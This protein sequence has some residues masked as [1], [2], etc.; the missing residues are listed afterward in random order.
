MGLNKFGL[1]ALRTTAFGQCRGCVQTCAQVLLLRMAR[2]HTSVVTGN[3]NRYTALAGIV[4][5]LCAAQPR[6]RSKRYR[7]HGGLWPQWIGAVLAGRVCRYPA[8]PRASRIASPDRAALGMK[9]RAG[10]AAT[11]SAK[12]SSACVEIKI[13]GTSAPKPFR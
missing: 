13:V 2:L 12:S 4:P 7:G 11:S 8:S 3:A 5:E 10:L 6:R 1:I 9:A